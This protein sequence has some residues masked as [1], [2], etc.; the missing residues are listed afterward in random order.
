MCLSSGK[1]NPENEAGCCCVGEAISQFTSTDCSTY[2]FLTLSVLS[3][4]QYSLTRVSHNK[5]NTSAS[6]D[7]HPNLLPHATV[8]SLRTRHTARGSHHPSHLTGEHIRWCHTDCRTCVTVVVAS[9]WMYLSTVIRS[10]WIINWP[11]AHSLCHKSSTSEFQSEVSLRVVLNA[12]VT[13]WG[14][15][16]KTA[17]GAQF[18]TTSAGAITSLQMTIWRGIS[19]RSTSGSSQSC[20]SFGVHINRYVYSLLLILWY[21]WQSWTLYWNQWMD[22]KYH[23][24]IW[25]TDSF[26]L[27]AGVILSERKH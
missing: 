23:V 15:T 24:K 27:I 6:N 12:H 2:T 5:S 1:H 18:N 11:K 17:E 3:W 16:D 10:P 26:Q 14:L 25:R 21:T 9:L 19:H 4:Q 22:V 7:L 20:Q 13:Q 8:E